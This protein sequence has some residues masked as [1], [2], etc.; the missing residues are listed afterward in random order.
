MIL[1]CGET[2]VDMVPADCGGRRGYLPRPGGSPCN[3]AVGLARLA[4]PAAFLGRISTEP[5][6]RLVWDH[7]RSNGVDMRHVREGP[8]HAL[9]SFVHAEPAGAASPAGAE[10]E[11]TFYAESSADL[12][13]R[14]SEV[15][16]A[17]G[18]EVR[19]LHL[20][21]FSTVLEPAATSLEGLMRRERGTRLVS[22]DPNVRPTLID[23]SVACRSRVEALVAAADV[24]KLSVADAAWLY[25]GADVAGVAA[26]WLGLGPTLL[27]ITRGAEGATAYRRDATVDAPAV[28][29]RAVDTVGAGDAW[30]AGSLAWLHRGGHLERSRLARLTEPE[31]ADMLRYANRVAAITCTREGADPPTAREVAEDLES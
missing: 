23:D 13:L 1:V 7:L 8:E 5:L 14:P 20:G 4:V 15:P 3:V 21:S 25:P 26:R 12:N 18:A 22:F 30:M 28:P 10:V 11:Y 24:V 31:L 6:G 9:L 29:V 16:E 19:A 17:L 27:V 2:V